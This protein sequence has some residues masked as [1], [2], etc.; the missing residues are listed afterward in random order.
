MPRRA[1]FDIPRLPF[2]PDSRGS[3]LGLLVG[4]VNATSSAAPLLHSMLT[5]AH[6]RWLFYVFRPHVYLA[7]YDAD[8]D[9]W[10]LVMKD[11]DAYVALDDA[12]VCD[13]S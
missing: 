4:W 1:S 9:Q 5:C 7:T 8:K 11:V 10:A 2:A 12:Y 13:E 6:R 3:A